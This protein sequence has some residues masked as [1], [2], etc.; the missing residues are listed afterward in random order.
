MESD[1]L[2]LVGTTIADKYAVESVVGEGGFAVVYRATHSVWKRPVAIKVFKALGD[3]SAERR[4][5]LLDDFV[6]EG[7]LLAELSERSAAIVQARDIGM[8]VLAQGDQVPFM[9]LEWLDGETLEELLTRESQLGASPRAIE[10]AV[11]LLGPVAEALALAHQKGIAH[12]DVKPGNVFVVGD[13][14]GEYKVKLLDFGI[15]KVVQEAQKEGFRKTTGLHTSFT[16]LYGAPEQFDRTLG[17]TGPWTDVF[18]FALVLIEVMLGREAL[19]GDNVAQLAFSAV[20]ER[21]RPTP[22]SFGLLVNDLVED[23]CAQAL[24]VKP[25]DRFQNAGEFWVA[26][27][28]ALSMGPPSGFTLASAQ[29]R[30][31][32]PVSSV[33]GPYPSALGTTPSP[34]TAMAASPGMSALPSTASSVGTGATIVDAATDLRASPRVAEPKAAKGKLWM[35]VGVFAVLGAAGLGVAKLQSAKG[36]SAPVASASAAPTLVA[37]VAPSAAPVPSCPKGMREVE[38]SEFFMGTDDPKANDAE[39]PAHAVKLSRYCLDEFEVTASEYKTCS[40]GG[41]CKRAVPTNEWEGISARQRKLYDPICNANDLAARGSH[42]MNCIDYTAAQ[43]YCEEMRGGRLPT[44]AEWELAARGSDGRVYPWGDEPPAPGLLNACGSECVGWGRKNP[45]PDGPLAAMYKSDDGFPHTSPV[46]S[47][48][49]GQT[50]HG[51]KDMV[52][53]V[54]EWVAD[55]HAPYTAGPKAID[56]KGPAKGEERGIRGGAWNGGDPAWLRPTYRFSAP[57]VM[58]SHGIGFRCA[59]PG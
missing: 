57:A 5:E 29:L 53:N 55:F 22:R 43:T 4:Q 49:R 24:A 51:M 12:R 21:R 56:P 2:N 52:G 54:W 28:S 39:R 13:V 50:S 18:A 7:A 26:L 46:G 37:S 48:P 41:K 38:A 16:P 42:P 8:V 10:A 15:A 34:S 32:A 31:V 14:E 35:A 9:V 45:D 6:R 20:D 33:R 23:V 17:A 40:D 44:E 30:R 19:V 47:F 58:R 27:R 3:V 59:K 11:E 25:E 1:P 36:G